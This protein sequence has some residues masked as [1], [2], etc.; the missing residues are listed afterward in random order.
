MVNNSRI[1][2]SCKKKENFWRMKLDVNTRQCLQSKYHYA[3]V[4]TPTRVIYSRTGSEHVVMK[5][6]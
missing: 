2:D 4:I 5:L 1:I 6:A 3:L